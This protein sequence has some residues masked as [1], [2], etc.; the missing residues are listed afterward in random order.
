MSVSTP[1]PEPPRSPMQQVLR[2]RRHPLLGQF[3]RFGVVGAS[4]TVIAFLIYAVLAD[5]LGVP[6]LL[7]SAVGFIVGA[8]NSYLL[9]R[10]WTFRAQ[11]AGYSTAPR[12]ALVQGT[13]LGI[14]LL[15][16]YLL[17]SQAGLE[18]NIGQILA[19]VVV[20]MVTF[21]AQRWWTFADAV[22]PS[23][24]A[25]PAVAPAEPTPATPVR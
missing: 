4:N 21:V 17:V 9:N 19:T 16:V 10:S 2:L 24:P 8:V 13:G 1:L 15:V 5:A 14:N 7:A 6:Y 22:G 11:H 3:V 20:E 12:F 25:E 18:K 23:A